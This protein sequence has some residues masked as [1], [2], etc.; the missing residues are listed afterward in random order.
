MIIANYSI[1][2]C[3]LAFFLFLVGVYFSKKKY[4]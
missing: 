3:S 4:G 1:A 2:I